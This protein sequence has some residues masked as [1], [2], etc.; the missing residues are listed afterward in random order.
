MI[1]LGSPFFCLLQKTP[2]DSSPPFTQ[3]GTSPHQAP[4]QTTTDAN[5]SY[6]HRTYH[7]R[8]RR[9]RSSPECPLTSQATT[10]G[11]VGAAAA[12]SSSF[13]PVECAKRSSPIGESHRRRCPSQS[14]PPSASP[15]LL[16]LGVESGSQ[17]WHDTMPLSRI[18]IRS[19]DSPA[20]VLVL[21][22][23]IVFSSFFCFSF[24][25][26][27]FVLYSGNVGAVT[28]VGGTRR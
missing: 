20:A 9:S 8:R 11:V 21:V 10:E 19:S 14:E 4:P 26:C 12:S 23:A 24:S 6:S 2:K 3:R 18:S 27:W 17:P 13:P 7:V 15:E 16:T 25:L 22:P 1:G 28:S 5:S